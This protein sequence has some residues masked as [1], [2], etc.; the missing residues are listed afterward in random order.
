MMGCVFVS[1]LYVLLG[2][3]RLVYSIY[4][5]LMNFMPRYHFYIPIHAFAFFCGL[6]R[7][8]E[9]DRTDVPSE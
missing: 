4:R 1:P 6:R 3:K 7:R 8:S 9:L 5:Q 2:S